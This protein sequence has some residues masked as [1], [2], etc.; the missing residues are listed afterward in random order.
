MIFGSVEPSL[1]WNCPLT[2]ILH[3]S[4]LS[5]QRVVV[6]EK[7]WNV[8]QRKPFGACSFTSGWVF[9]SLA[10]T[11]QRAAPPEGTRDLRCCWSIFSF[12]SVASAPLAPWGKNPTLP[13]HSQ[14]NDDHSNV[15]QQ[16]RGKDHSECNMKSLCIHWEH[17]FSLL[18]H[19]GT[20]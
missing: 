18:N 6:R 9:T 4:F 2:Q 7:G 17:S 20:T 8:G 1:S 5:G 13:G 10:W 11:A 14:N 16:D 3:A 15:Q 12:P 19:L